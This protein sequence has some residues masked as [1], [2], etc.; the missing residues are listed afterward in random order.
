MSGA[1]PASTDCGKIETRIAVALK[2]DA[3]GGMDGDLP[4]ISAQPR[5]AL[6][7][8]RGCSDDAIDSRQPHPARRGISG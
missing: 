5:L 4:P 7:R 2:G 3:G 6:N 1:E 8:G